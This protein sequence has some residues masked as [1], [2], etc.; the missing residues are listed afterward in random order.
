[1]ETA[2]Q[3]GAA[4]AETAVRGA[5]VINYP[6][7]ESWL[8][9]RLGGIG[10]SESAALFGLSPYHSTFSLWAEKSRQV[11]PIAVGSKKM[12]AGTRLEPVIADWYADDNPGRK[13]W[14][15]GRWA[16]MWHP[17]V[18]SMFATPDR[19][20]VEA[21]DRP[22][23]GLLEV[24]N[25]AARDVWQDGPPLHYRVQAQHQLAVTGRDWCTIVVLLDGWE[26]RAWDVER[27]PDFIAELEA[28]CAL[29]W[30]AVE[31]KRPPVVDGHKATL[32][33]LKRLH[34]LDNGQTVALPA[35]LAAL[36]AEREVLQAE[37]SERKRRADEIEARFRDV[38]GAASYGETPDGRRWSLLHTER[39]GY[40]VDACV[41]RTLRAVKVPSNRKNPKKA[42]G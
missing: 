1:M 21:S 32:A 28:Q 18:S 16:F 23:D 33:A 25:S 26:L 35:D 17:S 40:K 24:K 34:P 5:E 22:G 6:D 41:Y 7:R 12:E 27:D 4:P 19:W 30:A 15:A 10:A 36:W 13:I 38:I 39:E 29:F 11:A 31:S 2:P 42:S 9:A 37:I 14:T 20:I 3:D 8:E